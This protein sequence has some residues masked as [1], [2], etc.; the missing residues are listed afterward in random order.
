M[1]DLRRQRPNGRDWRAHLTAEEKKQVAS[2]ER[3]I[4]KLSDHLTIVRAKRLRI[5][6]RAT[7]RAANDR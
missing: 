2:L 6:N 7:V 4:E 1:S 5:Q 3:Q